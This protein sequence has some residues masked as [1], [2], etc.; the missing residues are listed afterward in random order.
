MEI[1]AVENLSFVYAGAS[2]KKALDGVS[3]KV[4]KGDFVT[5][6]GA[7]GSGKSTL[8]RML[9]RELVPQGELS[10]GVKYCGRD[11]QELSAKESAAEI[12]F[13]SQS[14][15]QSIVTDRV[16]SELA[17]GLENLG[18]STEEI[19]RKTAETAAFFGIEEWF[20]RKTDELSGGQKQIVALAAVMA[21]QPRVLCLDEPTSQLDPIAAAEF[22]NILVKLSRE[23]A[24]TVIVVEHRLENILPVSN[25]LMVLD[26]GRILEY[27]EV[28]E[29]LAAARKHSGLMAGM[30]AA[31]RVSSALSEREAA[32]TVKEGREFI[33]RN[34]GNEIRSFEKEKRVIGEEIALEVK[35]VHFRYSKEGPDALRGLDLS[36]KKGEIFCILGGN[37]SGKTTALS[38]MSGISREYCGKVKIFGKK[39]R[40]YGGELYNG[41]VAVLPQDV[42]T[43]FSKNSVREELLDSKIEVNSAPYGLCEKLGVHPY[44]LSCGERQLLALAKVIA[45]KP[46]LLF[47]DEPTKALDGAARD[48]IIA[49][50]KELRDGGCTVVAVSHDTE[51][52][53]KCADRCAL[54]FKGEVIS[55]ADTEEFFS[56]NYFYTTQAA[57][58]TRGYYERAVTAEDVI[59]LCKINKRKA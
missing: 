48:R 6:C 37:G 57:R 28:K 23:L 39:L 11:L 29:V 32:L 38:V 55:V 1:F 35:G 59:A 53:V 41:T 15:E 49:A 31:V 26:E 17:F 58:M 7:G 52:A 33:E 25:K 47:L 42:Q 30:P 12:G 24:V 2:G 43:V 8:L 54:F 18:L 50:V 51:F 3:F 45:R 5:I 16:W 21:A 19:R 22:V 40:E 34:F 4:E 46:K 56:T 13:V 36:V 27:G 44:D 9:K 10:G 20:E 14:P